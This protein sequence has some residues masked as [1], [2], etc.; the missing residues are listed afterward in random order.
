MLVL[1]AV[2]LMG[3]AG[4]GFYAVRRDVVRSLPP[5]LREAGPSRVLVDRFIWSDA[6]PKALRRRFVLTQMCG[7]GACA[8][9]STFLYADHGGA[10]ALLFGAVTLAGAGYY[11]WRAGR[12]GL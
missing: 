5:N 3:I 9:L 8:C 12:H 6:A 2:V 4:W 1:T 10:P 11:G 7:V